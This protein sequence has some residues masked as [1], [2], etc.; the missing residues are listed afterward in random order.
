MI[1]NDAGWCKQR[2]KLRVKYLL[3]DLGKSPLNPKMSRLRFRQCLNEYAPFGAFL[4][5][6]HTSAHMALAS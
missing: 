4:F 5:L 3:S 6:A 1:V 2:L